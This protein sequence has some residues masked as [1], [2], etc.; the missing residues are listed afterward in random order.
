MKWSK[1]ILHTQLNTIWCQ[2]RIISGP[3]KIIG[4]AGKWLSFKHI[5][6]SHHLKTIEMICTL[7]FFFRTRYIDHPELIDMDL[8]S[9]KLANCVKNCDTMFCAAYL[10][11]TLQNT[12][13]IIH[14]NLAWYIW[15]LN[16]NT[17]TIRNLLYLMYIWQ[18]VIHQYFFGLPFCHFGTH[19]IWSRTLQSGLHA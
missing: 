12:F 15:M 7:Y 11:E 3:K 13:N 8:S 10:E 16:A 14:Y 18:K 1:C 17:L 9:L 19:T 2:A 4:L 5:A 6:V